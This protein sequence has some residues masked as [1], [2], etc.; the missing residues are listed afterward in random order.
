MI[1]TRQP[2]AAHYSAQ[3]AVRL[4]QGVVELPARPSI[5]GQ[6][7]VGGKTES[8]GPLGQKFAEVFPHSEM[9]EK[10]WEMA[11]TRLQQAALRHAMAAAGIEPATLDLHLGGDLLNQCSASNFTMR[12]SA[13]P[14]VGLYSACATFAQSLAM[15]ALMLAGGGLSR[16]SACASSHFCAAEK[17]FRYPLEYGGQ[18]SPTAQ[19][20]ATAAGAL[21]L[22]TADNTHRVGISHVIFGNVMDLGVTDAN[23]MGAAMAPAAWDTI[24]RFLEATHTAPQDYDC[25]L[26]GDLGGI[27]SALLLELAQTEGQMDLS[28]I[29]RDS[30]LL[31]YH[32]G[33]QDVGMGGSGAGCS[34][35][36][37][38]A[39]I[40]PRLHAGELKNV[41]FVGTGALLSATS[42]LQGESIPAVAHGVK[43]TST[44]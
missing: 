41:L 15:G 43:L 13:W 27:G 3:S 14:F 32:T 8:E 1:E 9:D 34:A 22:G 5:L 16:V 35:A 28:G 12:D 25:I 38:C 24:K 30:G 40:L 4:A 2:S 23:E 36:V 31:L 11:E 17:Q 6:A 42:P 18:P 44:R 33:E 29:H 21:V 20:T 39:D 19:R 37:L 7:A 26:T 10:C